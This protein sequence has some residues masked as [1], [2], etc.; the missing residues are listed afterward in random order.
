MQLQI[1]SIDKDFNNLCG[2]KKKQA[3][4]PVIKYNAW[5]G[6]GANGNNRGRGNYRTQPTQQQQPP[7]QQQ[8]QQ[9]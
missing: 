2:K 6:R 5:I 1:I 8:P 4:I 9:Q 3:H 7:Q